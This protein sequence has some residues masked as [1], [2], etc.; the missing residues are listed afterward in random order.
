MRGGSANNIY[1]IPAPRILT[2]GMGTLLAAAC[3]IPAILSLVSMWNKILEINW[4]TRF[5]DRDADQPVDEP[6]EGT[7]GA[8][9]AKM[10]SVNAMVRQFLSAIEIPVFGA[11]VLAIL[12]I[13]E[14][15]FRSKPVGYQTEPLASVGKATPSFL[16]GRPLTLS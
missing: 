15:N 3:C 14:R 6:I 4:K 10:K 2:F 16:I 11:A 13:G 8:T 1:I 5:G 7:N 9:I 12:I